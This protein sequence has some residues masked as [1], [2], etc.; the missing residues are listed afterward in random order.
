M[1]D[2]IG[3]VRLVSLVH[4]PDSSREEQLPFTSLVSQKLSVLRYTYNVFEG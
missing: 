3:T 1:S 2:V 4:N